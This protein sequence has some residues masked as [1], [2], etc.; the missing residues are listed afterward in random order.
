MKNT[1]LYHYALKYGWGLYH[2]LG[3]AFRMTTYLRNLEK[4]V[5]SK[6]VRENEKVRQNLETGRRVDE[7]IN[8][9]H[10]YTI[11]WSNFASV[12]IFAFYSCMSFCSCYID[13]KWWILK[14]PG[15]CGLFLINLNH[16]TFT[17]KLNSLS[18]KVRESCA[19]ESG[20]SPCVLQFL[21]LCFMWKFC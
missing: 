14:A 17:I 5:N 19:L 21:F 15:L 10:I 16:H 11:I 13:I 1:A 9:K 3:C 18:G 4:L 12:T 7:T 8:I 6:V 2:T 20:Q